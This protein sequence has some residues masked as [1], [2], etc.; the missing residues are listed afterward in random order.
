MLLIN[1]MQRKRWSCVFVAEGPFAFGQADKCSQGDAGLGTFQAVSAW[2]V[3]VFC[4]FIF[5]ISYIQTS[6]HCE[7]RIVPVP[8]PLLMLFLGDELVSPYKRSKWQ[9]LSWTKPAGMGS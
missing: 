3:N 8:T 2:T 9:V 7:E 5:I 6:A 4:S 1:A